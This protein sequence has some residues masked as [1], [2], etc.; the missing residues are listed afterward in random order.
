MAGDRLGVHGKHLHLVDA[1]RVG[2]RDVYTF[3]RNERPRDVGNLLP[4]GAR[5][6]DGAC[7]TL[8]C[9]G[10]RCD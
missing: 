2:D 9:A 8:V 6:Y 10:A 4:F 5:S 1:D 7:V 3:C